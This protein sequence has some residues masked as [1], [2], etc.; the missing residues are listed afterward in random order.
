MICGIYKIENKING[1]I[2]I[3]QS[4][5]INKRWKAEIASSNNITDTSYNTVL[6]QAFRKYGIENFD[7]QIIEECPKEQLN[8]REIYWISYYN[9][10]KDGYNSTKGGKQSSAPQKLTDETIQLIY[11]DLLNSSLTMIEIAKKYKVSQ[12]FISYVN[13][14]KNWFNDK[15]SYPI[16][17]TKKQQK[18]IKNNHKNIIIL[19]KYNKKPPTAEELKKVLYEQNGNFTQV[20]KIFK[21]SPSQIRRLCE[22][23][24]LPSHSND[25]KSQKQN[26]KKI[27]QYKVAQIDKQT[28]EIIKIFDSIT[29]AEEK[30]GITHIGPA[31][32]PNNLTRKSAGGY[33]WKRLN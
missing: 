3:G 9:S 33:I 15:W 17:K 13:T 1:H 23:Y 12:A 28:G 2:Y 30:T 22:Y 4:T 16:R 26:I 11:E 31:S 27:I 29:Q 21:T 18:K 25:Y 7:F 10:F 20:S 19:K 14:G 8:E 24:N 32:D 5:N 6:S